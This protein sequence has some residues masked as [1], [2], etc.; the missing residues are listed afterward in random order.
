MSFSKIELQFDFN[1]K[2]PSQFWNKKIIISIQIFAKIIKN[3]IANSRIL[4]RMEDG[5]FLLTY[6]KHFCMVSLS[7]QSSP[8]SAE[9]ISTI[10][11]D[12]GSELR[13]LKIMDE[14]WVS[15][16]SNPQYHRIQKSKST[17]E[18]YENYEKQRN[19][20]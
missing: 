18:Y 9:A 5:N 13:N 16:S 14:W 10:E 7:I 17:L 19:D 12:A 6:K 11:W 20:C 1:L 8:L 3:K 4:E 2:I 15:R